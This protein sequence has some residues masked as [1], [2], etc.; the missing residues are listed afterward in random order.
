MQSVCFCSGSRVGCDGLRK[1]RRHACRYSENPRSRITILR[2][3]PAE[4]ERE[5]SA[6]RSIQRTKMRRAVRCRV[7]AAQRLA[8]NTQRTRRSERENSRRRIS[9]HRVPNLLFSQRR[10]HARLCSTA[11]AR[12]VPFAS[13]ASNETGSRF[14]PFRFPLRPPRTRNDSRPRSMS[15][16]QSRRQRSVW[17]RSHPPNSFRGASTQMFSC[18]GLATGV[19]SP[20]AIPPGGTASLGS[21]GL[22]IGWSNCGCCTRSASNI[23]VNKS[24]AAK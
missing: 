24:A 1:C 19:I 13:Q 18:V 16:S 8:T 6:A 3:E 20:G 15:R 22:P 12:I 10:Q 9:R 21:I 23:A 17:S 11:P 4:R 7:T 5:G 2:R 14:A